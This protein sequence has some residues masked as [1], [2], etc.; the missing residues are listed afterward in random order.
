MSSTSNLKLNKF[1]YKFKIN[2]KLIN[3]IIYFL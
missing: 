3:R 2:I 1:N